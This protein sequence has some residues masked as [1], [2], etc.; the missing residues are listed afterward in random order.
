[1]SNTEM[2]SAD[3]SEERNF[4]MNK[5]LANQNFFIPLTD[6]SP[7]TEA[8]SETMLVMEGSKHGVLASS[9]LIADVSPGEG[10]P[11]HLHYT[12][13][14][15]VLPE[16][17]AEFLIGDKRFTV[18]G[19]GI[20]HIPAKTPHTFV[21]IGDKPARIVTFFPSSSYEINWEVLGPNPLL[22]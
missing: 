12:E 5:A 6:L 7:L 17:R 20:V 8:P 4:T 2:H 9:V 19:P 3:N 11:L 18:D 13:E 1:M 22:K 10:P 21:N 15:Q 14:I 16:C